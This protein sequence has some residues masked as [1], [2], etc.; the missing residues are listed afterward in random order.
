MPYY[1]FGPNDIFNNTIETHPKS[2]F[3]IHN[4]KIYYN[5]YVSEPSSHSSESGTYI[6]HIPSGYISMYEI[7]IDRQESLHSSSIAADSTT[8]PLAKVGTMIYPF[9]TKSGTGESLKSVSNSDE[10]D[11]EHGDIMTGSYPMSA[12]LS[13]ERYV[14]GSSSAD[15]CNSFSEASGKSR[16]R[17]LALKN[18][19]NHYKYLSNKYDFS[20]FDESKEVNLVSIPSIFYGSSIKKGSVSIKYYITGSLA[21][22]LQATKRNGELIQVSGSSGDIGKVAGVVLYNEGFAVLTGSWSLND[23]VSERYK[24]CPNATTAGDQCDNPRWKYWGQLGDPD[25]TGETGQTDCESTAVTSS[26]FHMSFEGTNYIPVMTMFAH[27]KKGELNHSSNPTYLTYD[28]DNGN[29]VSYTDADRLY[30][31]YAEKKDVAI[32]NTVKSPY[33]NHNALFQKQTWISQIGIYDEDMNLIAVAK[34][35][36]PVRKTE[37]RDFTFKLKVDF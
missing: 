34:L 37:D 2:E 36:N 21:G 3:L 22:E 1:K 30:A 28:A 7:N 19:L 11:F 5:G 15:V 29:I 6:K 33:E 35:A 16:P 18:T 13:V 14:S 27:A 32:K 31:E 23:S 10:A 9:I 4:R 8:A 12:S 24:W 26:S 20:N 17:M 25:D